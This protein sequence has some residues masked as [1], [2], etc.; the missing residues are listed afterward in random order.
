[1]FSVGPLQRS[2]VL[3][4]PPCSDHTKFE[5]FAQQL[6]L[7]AE[8]TVQMF[9]HCYGISNEPAPEDLNLY[10][11]LMMRLFQ[12]P[13]SNYNVVVQRPVITREDSARVEGNLLALQ[14]IGFANHGVIKCSV[15]APIT[16]VPS[17][18]T[19]FHPT[20]VCLLFRR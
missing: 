9:G 8:Q 16:L 12:S 18:P 1:M 10:H 2:I 13:A 6:L 11:F 15:P 14:E 17:A 7:G 3:L 5:A 19:H 20:S 4:L